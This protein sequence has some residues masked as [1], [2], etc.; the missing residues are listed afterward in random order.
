VKKLF[1]SITHLW[2]AESARIMSI[3][4][5]LAAA[6]LIPGVWGK[7]IGAVIPILGG[8]AV[9]ATVFSPLTVAKI[10]AANRKK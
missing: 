10:R 9:R 8:Q 7:V 3:I 4:L 6:G 5:A 2:Q 1:G